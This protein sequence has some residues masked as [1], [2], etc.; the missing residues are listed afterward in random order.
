MLDGKMVKLW[1]DGI[2][3]GL[4]WEKWRLLA[5]KILVYTNFISRVFIQ[6]SCKI[7]I[8]NKKLL[9]ELKYYYVLLILSALTPVRQTSIPLGYNN[10]ITTIF[11]LTSPLVVVE[12]WNSIEFRPNYVLIFHRLRPYLF[13]L[14]IQ[15]GVHCNAP[16]WNN[17]IHIAT[18]PQ[19][20]LHS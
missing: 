13:H 10:K 5:K 8:G 16:R 15:K 14:H 20:P 7:K 3:E 11:R 2:M 18:T 12:H 6:T 4:V 9:T 1:D 19:D 17:R